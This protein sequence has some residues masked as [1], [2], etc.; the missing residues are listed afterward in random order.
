MAC[1]LA[2]LLL[3]ELRLIVTDGTWVEIPGGLNLPR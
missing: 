3:G 2:M 1:A